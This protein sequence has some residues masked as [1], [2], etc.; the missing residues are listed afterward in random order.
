VAESRGP[1]RDSLMTAMN[2]NYLEKLEL[3][4]PQLYGRE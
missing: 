3:G 1:H 2:R 4:K